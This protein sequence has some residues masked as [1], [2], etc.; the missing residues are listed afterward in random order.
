M[1]RR[2]ERKATPADGSSPT[3]TEEDIVKQLEI[4]RLL[5]S[6]AKTRELLDRL[7]ELLGDL[8]SAAVQVTA[9]TREA[10]E[11]DLMVCLQW[12]GQI[13]SGKTREGL[14]LAEYLTEFGMVD[15]EVWT[16]QSPVA[17]ATGQAMEGAAT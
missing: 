2:H 11:S 6:G 3:R 14:L 9:Y 16:R 5:A 10:L 15:H 17:E 4:I 12:S 8:Q 13:A 1:W 7:P